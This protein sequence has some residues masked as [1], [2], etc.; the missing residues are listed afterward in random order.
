MSIFLKHA[1]PEVYFS[2]STFSCEDNLPL[3]HAPC[4]AKPRTDRVLFEE[5]IK[6]WKY[7]ERLLNREEKISKSFLM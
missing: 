5:K 2:K 4:K 7:Q 3:N 6:T 1:L